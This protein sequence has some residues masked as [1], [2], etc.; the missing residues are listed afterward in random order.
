MSTLTERLHELIAEQQKGHENEPRHTIGEQLKDI[1]A[2]EPNCAEILVQDLTITGMDLAAAEK[3]LQE[4]ADKHRG[5]ARAYCIPPTLAE[6]LLR[7][8][9]KLPEA[10]QAPAEPEHQEGYID[11]SAFL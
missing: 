5:S 9:Y 2:R 7:D 6:K 10:G 1:A 11:L 4:Y 3:M 8:F